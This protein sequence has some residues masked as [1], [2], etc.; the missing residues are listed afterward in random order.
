MKFCIKYYYLI[1]QIGVVRCLYVLSMVYQISSSLSVCECLF[2]FEYFS[3][4]SLSMC[5]HIYFNVLRDDFF[6][7]LQLYD[8]IQFFVFR[9]IS[10]SFYVLLSSRISCVRLISFFSYTHLFFFCF[11]ISFDCICCSNLIHQIELMMHSN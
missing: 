2:P 3:F 10:L 4:F 5:V 7:R 9:M 1:K 6:F 11:C 8:N